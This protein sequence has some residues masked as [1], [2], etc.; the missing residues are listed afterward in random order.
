LCRRCLH[1]RAA[2]AFIIAATDCCIY[3]GK[4]LR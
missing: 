1:R 3:L 2:A 4:I